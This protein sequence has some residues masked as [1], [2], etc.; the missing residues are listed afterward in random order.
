MFLQS[1]W[2]LWP[3]FVTVPISVILLYR[4][5]VCV[6]ESWSVHGDRERYD[7]YTHAEY[8]PT[9]YLMGLFEYTPRQAATDPEAGA[10]DGAA[11]AGVGGY[12]DDF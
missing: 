10:A 7:D 5:Y 4:A 1:V 6:R 3:L 9:D 2:K 8:T 12:R 11:G